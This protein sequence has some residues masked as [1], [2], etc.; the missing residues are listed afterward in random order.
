MGLKSRKN[1]S[2]TY[3]PHHDQSQDR[4][5][6]SVQDSFEVDEDR[7][8][9]PQSIPNSRGHSAPSSKQRK[10]AL[11]QIDIPYHDHTQISCR[12]QRV[13]NRGRAALDTHKYPTTTLTINRI[14]SAKR[15]STMI[16]TINLKT[17]V[18]KPNRV[19]FCAEE[20]VEDS[21]QPAY[22]QTNLP[23]ANAAHQ[24]PLAGHTQN[25][26]DGWR[27]SCP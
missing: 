17:A 8:K 14:F 7:V 13:L 12:S 15:S 5:A 20:R 11:L 21:R 18:Q 4:R 1:A 10:N 27:H 22:I 25:R 24:V 19:E 16:T 3:T 2:N 26:C 6:K 9:N 23:L